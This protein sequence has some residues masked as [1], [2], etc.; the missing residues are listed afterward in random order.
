MGP[1]GKIG[2]GLGVGVGAFAAVDIGRYLLGERDVS[3]G[4]TD[5]ATFTGKALSYRHVIGFG[6]RNVLRPEALYLGYQSQ[7]QAIQRERD[8][9]PTASRMGYENGADAFRHSYAASLLAYRLVT[10]AGMTPESAASFTRA[11]GVAHE[12]DS[13]LSG[14]HYERSRAMDLHNNDVGISIGI[15]QA[16]AGVS[17]TQSDQRIEGAVLSAIADGR[18]QVVEAGELRASRRSDV[19]RARR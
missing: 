6:L 8:L 11:A 2:V 14:A 3:E 13:Q 10:D 9:F 16:L 17:P 19:A 5:H 12:N 1:I 15:E 7:R 18:M 4:G